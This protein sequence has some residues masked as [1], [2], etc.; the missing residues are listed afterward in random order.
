M[1]AGLPNYEADMAVL[2]MACVKEYA[3]KGPCAWKKENKCSGRLENSVKYNFSRPGL[4]VHIEW[5][6]RSERFQL[7]K[8]F[9]L[10]FPQ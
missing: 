1:A 8:A 6:G 5:K 2:N 9:A 10:L 4:G 3:N 7:A